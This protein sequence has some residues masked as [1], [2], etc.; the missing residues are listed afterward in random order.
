[1]N[2]VSIKGFRC[3]PSVHSHNWHAFVTTQIKLGVKVIL[4]L[5][6]PNALSLLIREVSH[7]LIFELEWESEGL[8]VGGVQDN[9]IGGHASGSDD[10]SRVR[11]FVALEEFLLNRVK[12]ALLSESLD[13]AFHGRVEEVP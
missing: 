4:Q 1:M 9:A 6:V 13:T 3:I 5:V 2:P 8:R 12:F 7:T 11:S 10:R